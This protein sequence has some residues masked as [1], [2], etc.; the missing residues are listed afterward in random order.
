MHNSY[1]CTITVH[2]YVFMWTPASWIVPPYS[3]TETDGLF[4]RKYCIHL[5]SRHRK[6]K[7]EEKLI[8]P[9]FRWKQQFP[10]TLLPNYMVLH[11]QR[12]EYSY[13]LPRKP[14]TSLVV[15]PHLSLICLFN[16]LCIWEL[17]IILIS[18]MYRTIL[19]CTT[20]DT[21]YSVT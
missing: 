5:Q 4:R 12:Q 1:L 20:A 21:D 3:F 6:Q 17:Q 10:P 16:L 7:T 14:Q 19:T 15:I 8:L 11:P 9:S 2:K 13:S 18:M